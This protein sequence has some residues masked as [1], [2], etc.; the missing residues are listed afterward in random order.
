MNM[1]WLKTEESLLENLVKACC[2]A[3]APG[4]LTSPTQPL[5]WYPSS[6]RTSEVNW[7][8]KNSMAKRHSTAVL[9][10]LTPN[11]YITNAAL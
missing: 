1:F 2:C 11:A 3:V 8:R 10:F 9:G 6:E 4:L 5:N 7:E